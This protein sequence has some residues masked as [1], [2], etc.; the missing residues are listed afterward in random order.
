V[1]RYCGEAELDDMRKNRGWAIWLAA[2]SGLS[3]CSQTQVVENTHAAVTVHYG[4]MRT[5]SDATAAA[6][7]A[8]AAHGK[9]AKLRSTQNLG[10]AEHSAHFDCIGG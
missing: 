1:I 4:G 5:L 6:E 9:A 3:A 10:L 8:C 2:L 7:K